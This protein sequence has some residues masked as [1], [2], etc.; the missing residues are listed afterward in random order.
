MWKA[1]QHRTTKT[2]RNG[3]ATRSRLSA[4]PLEQ[5]VVPTV[6]SN[7]SPIT[8]N[9]AGNASPYPSTISVATPAGEVLTK[10]T[11]TL[12]GL[13][14]TFVNDVDI[15]LVGPT[16]VNIVL[17]SDNGPDTGAVGVA[18]AT[19]TFADSA[20]TTIGANPVVDGTYKPENIGPGDP[21]PGA[22][23]TP[24]S[25]TLAAFLGSNPNG[26]WELRVV[27][28]AAGDTGVIS[29]GWSL[30]ITSRLN[31]AP[32][33]VDDGFSVNEDKTLS[34][35]AK[36]VL[37]N[38]TDGDADP[39]TAILVSGP[40]NG[41]L[42]LKS[43]GSFDYAPNANF[44]GTDSFTYKANDS[45]TDS[46]LAKVTITVNPVDDA[47]V[48][49]VDGYVT[50]QNTAITRD[51]ASGVLRNDL[52]ADAAPR[53]TLFLEDF[54]TIPLEA[55]KSP[56]TIGQGDGTDWT[57]TLPAGWKR[58]QSTTPQGDPVEYFGFHV[59][60]V[61]SWISEQ[62]DQDR[63]SFTRGGV[64]KHGQVLVGD[65]DA[66][67]DGTDIDIPMSQDGKMNVFA[68]TRPIS[69]AGVIGNSARLEFD[70]SFRPYYNQTG[71]VDVSFDGGTTWQ[72]VLEINNV[73]SGGNSSLDRANEHVLVPIA[74][75]GQ[76]SMLVRFGYVNV[77]NDWWWAID[78]VK[79]TGERTDFSS[80]SAVK[81]TDPTSGKLTLNANGSFTY[82]PNTGFLGNDSFSYKAS[83]G[84]LEGAVQTVTINVVAVN[85]SA[86]VSNADRYSLF[87]A[88]TLTVVDNYGVLANDTDAESDPLI[89]TLVAKPANGSLAL[90]TNGSFVYT[91]SGKF[92]GSDT[93]TY[94]ASD[95][96]NDGPVTTVTITVIQNNFSPPVAKD[97][98]FVVTED[99][100]L[101]VAVPGVLGN[102][103]DADGNPLTAVLVAGPNHGAITF[104]SDGSFKYTPFGGFNGADS[105]TYLAKDNQ[106][107]SNIAT[108]KITVNDDPNPAAINDSYST[109]AGNKLSVSAPG[110][111]TN[112][113]QDGTAISLLNIDFEGFTLDPFAIGGVPPVVGADGTDWTAS[114]PPGWTLDNSQ[115]PTGGWQAYEG[116]HLMD[117]DSWIAQQGGQGRELFSRGGIGLHGT[118]AV[119][120]GDAYDDAPSFSIEPNLMNTFLVTPDISLAGL[121]PGSVRVEFDS[122]FRPYDTQTGVVEAS[123]DG[124]TSWVNVLTLNS[125]NSGGDSSLDRIN[126]R[127]GI[128]VANPSTGNVRFRFGLV[129]TG[130]DWYWA[131]DNVAITGEQGV[132]NLTAQKVTDPAHGVLTLNSN[133]SFDYTPNPGF[134]GLD[135]FTYV[136][137][138]GALT[139]P[140]ANV[141]IRV[142][143]TQAPRV[144]SVKINDG[145]VQR[146]N[147]TSVKVA[148]DQ[149][150]TFAGAVDAAFSLVR[151]SDSATVALAASVDNSGFGTVVTLTFAGGATDGQS[152]ADGRYTLTVLASQVSNVNGPLDGNGDL[153]PGD[154]FVLASAASPATATNIFRRFGDS[155]GDGDVD[156]ADFSAFRGAFGG[157]PSAI[158]DSDGDGDVD[159][160]DFSAFRARFSLP[161]P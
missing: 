96:K 132:G 107:S 127:I 148:F 146:S 94:K 60:D 129:N 119:A 18:N 133:G 64:G 15:L 141:N 95:G 71:L 153:T 121:L 1:W 38:D 139:S 144:G 136:A 161:V 61:D 90:T 53:A 17:M 26:N 4:L 151:Q 3:R 57:E 30:D 118:V 39:L 2:T 67:D 131:V 101:T 150:V 45:I 140:P 49:V 134:F 83:D 79:V 16:G 91:P 51:A 23:A 6:F 115:N 44:N 11:V 111:L 24:P 10:V 5:R 74:N 73:N 36:G 105:F 154:D 40:S 68:T 85:P 160:A 116:W 66:Y 147:V 97:E 27:D 28:D 157:G 32:A 20:A 145:A 124:G 21:F 59:M 82:T 52:H 12:T 113:R 108:V 22:P 58:D 25:L 63:A 159:L 88:T 81:V 120:D 72:N 86:P 31:K 47:P 103:T 42:T 130:N 128:N 137:K 54:E 80:I 155:D 112:D 41:S 138:S 9:D 114:L 35:A 87:E 55:F 100:V 78:N 8:I 7:P 89:A 142:E 152:L 13:S 126:E 123:F 106:F 135:S 19:L 92:V 50:F 70:S 34:V 76:G 122:C 143:A 93:F 158:F 69:L 109:L 65:G 149:Q 84:I 56:T 102:D 156:L 29:S 37:A 99:Q 33:A 75:P 62:G 117:I 43:D 46:N 125:T 77:A 48:T 104:N 98:S 110:V 14:H